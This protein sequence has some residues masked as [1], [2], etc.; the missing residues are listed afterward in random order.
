MMT[1]NYMSHTG[2]DGSTPRQRIER[3]GLTTAKGW[4]ENVA[5]GQATPEAVVTAWMNSSGHKANILSTT[6]THLGVGYVKNTGSATYGHYWTQKFV[7]L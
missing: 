5:A 6:S 1:N 7:I 2:N 4:S 3:A